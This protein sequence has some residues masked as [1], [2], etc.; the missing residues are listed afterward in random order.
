MFD[1]SDPLN[2]P[3]AMIEGIKVRRFDFRKE[4]LQ[5]EMLAAR[6]GSLAF[7]NQGVVIC[8]AGMLWKKG[9]HVSCK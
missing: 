2:D 9:S 8:H 4:G 5:K 3:W 7:R 1:T 6:G